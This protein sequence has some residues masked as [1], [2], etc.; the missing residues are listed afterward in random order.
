VD[1]LQPQQKKLMRNS[2][3]AADVGVLPGEHSSVAA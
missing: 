1:A 2:K 3:Q